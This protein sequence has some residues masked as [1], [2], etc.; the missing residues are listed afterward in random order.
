MDP[1]YQPA[2]MTENVMS[3]PTGVTRTPSPM[4]SC[5]TFVIR[6]PSAPVTP[7]IG[8]R[9]SILI[10]FLMDPRS[11]PAGMTMPG[12]HGRGFPL[13]LIAFP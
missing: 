10:S 6:H 2:G 7:D 9:E 5:P 4:P 13:S 12:R 11:P 8:H 3:R 1:R